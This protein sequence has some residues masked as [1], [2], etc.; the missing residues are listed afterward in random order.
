VS[1]HTPG[2]WKVG[3][4]AEGLWVYV[5][6]NQNVICDIVGRN[7]PHIMT[8]EDYANAYLIAA[9]PE[10]LGALEATALLAHELSNGIAHGGK[11][12]D[13]CDASVCTRNRALIAKAKGES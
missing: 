13:D 10:L 1:K 8:D 11:R 2:L 3:D 9:A 6:P 12:F 4:E 7:D 5:D